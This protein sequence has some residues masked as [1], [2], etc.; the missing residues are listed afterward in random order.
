MSW[1]DVVKLKGRDR[2]LREMQEQHEQ[3][4]KEKKKH[5]NRI[6]FYVGE[7]SKSIYTQTTRHLPSMNSSPTSH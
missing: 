4:Q 1:F 3:E 7:I 5:I 2:P 6:K